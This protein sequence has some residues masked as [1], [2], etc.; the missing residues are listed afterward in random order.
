[1]RDLRD[2]KVVEVNADM[3]KLEF[4]AAHSEEQI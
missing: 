4:G 2:K 1:M 3:E